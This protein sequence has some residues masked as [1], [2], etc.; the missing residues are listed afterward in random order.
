VNLAEQLL[1]IPIID[2]DR[3]DLERAERVTYLLEQSFRYDY[4]LPVER[5]R[6]RLVVLPPARHGNQ[7]LRAHT[8]AVDGVRA[9]REL[10]RD[11]RGNT[12][13]RLRADRVEDSVSFRITALLER[14]QG[15]GP[16]EIPVSALTDPR[17]LRPTR[18]TAPDDGLRDLAGDVAS[19]VG[20]TATPVDVAAA[21]CERVHAELGYEYGITGIDTTA[22]EALAGG[23]GVC[24]DAAH[25][26]LALCH[27]LGLPARYVSGH[28]LGQGGTHAWVEVLVER[29]DQAVAVPFDPCNGVPGSARYLTVATGRDY[30]DVRPTSGSYIGPAGGNL[31][32]SRRVAVLAAA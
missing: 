5:L 16:T 32:T 31:T 13:V 18:L 7:Y 4:P 9:R 15:D 1:P 27:V 3:V 17:S 20:R 26:M 30:T 6:H 23:R 21:L 14:V 22:A 24:Q 8:V 19:T 11:A 10:R 25:V 29:K 12:V 2:H 28:L